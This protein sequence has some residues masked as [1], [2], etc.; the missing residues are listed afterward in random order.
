MDSKF[1]SLLRRVVGLALGLCACSGPARVP[2]QPER[3]SAEPG[4]A[5]TNVPIARQPID[6]DTV[7]TLDPL[8]HAALARVESYFG[9]PFPQTFTLTVHPDRAAFDASFPPEWGLGA[10][11]RA[12]ADL[13]VSGRIVG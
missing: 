11:A 13:R 2:A 4:H 7:A 1:P 3:V 6:E 5:R 8:V 9:A 12:R 10:R